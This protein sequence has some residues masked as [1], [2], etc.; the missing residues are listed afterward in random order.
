MERLF[1]TGAVAD[2]VL[3]VMAVECLALTLWWRGRRGLGRAFLDSLSLIAPGV[4]LV[5]ALRAALTDQD[6]RV[7]AV[8]LTLSLPAH[9]LDVWRR[10]PA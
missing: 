2:L 6:W 5:L 7:V 9:L 3:A 4:F 1:A 8:W 10:R